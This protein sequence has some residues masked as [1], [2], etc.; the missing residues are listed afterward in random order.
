MDTVKVTKDGIDKE[1]QKKDLP[2]YIALGW[3]EVTNYVKKFA[4]VF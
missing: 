4:R 1:I 3:T 2:E